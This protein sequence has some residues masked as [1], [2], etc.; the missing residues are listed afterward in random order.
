MMKRRFIIGLLAVYIITVFALFFTF[1]SRVKADLM[2]GYT[3]A[4]QNI[5]NGNYI[6]AVNTL[7]ILGSNYKDSKKLIV[8]SE[9]RIAYDQGK[10]SEAHE[11]FISL[12]NFKDS[13][14]WA[15]KSAEEES[16]TEQAQSYNK[17]CK[18]YVDG[19]Y[20]NALNI[21]KELEDYDKSQKLTE[22]CRS[23]WKMNCA[24]IVSAGIRYS[25][26]ITK[27]K[28]A[29]FSGQSFEDAADIESWHNIVSVSACGEF[30]LGLTDDGN[31]L[32]AKCKSHY[33]YSTDTS[34]WKNIIAVSA[35]EQL[36]AV[37]KDDGTVDTRG[38]DGYGERRDVGDW[39]D[40][41]AIDTGWQHIVGLDVNGDIHVAGCYKR[42][43]TDEIESK[44][45]DWTDI[46]SISTGG[47][48]G[49]DAEG[50]AYK[51]S[52]HIVAL[53]R[54]GTVVA[55]GDNE[56]GQCNVTGPEWKNIVAVSAGDYHTVGLT[57]DGRVVTTQSEERFPDSY[58]EIRK[59][60][61]IVSISAGYGFTLA[62]KSDG[63][64]LAAGLYQDGQ[65]NVELWDIISRGELVKSSRIV[66]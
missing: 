4:V 35:G 23:A 58:N 1:T 39:K 49:T 52:G 53:K 3:L 30:V 37:L 2:D 17:A 7:N 41:I 6:D 56:Y 22:L 20:L 19:D 5:D 42:K 24:E 66:N 50:N 54:D 59:W 32:V 11:K 51:G 26:G 60:E 64:V 15:E 48:T 43:L 13:Q 45:S 47:S 57:A 55:A 63:T 44:K 18:Y 29:A 46:V 16:I 9:G 36:I 38:V 40:I 27:D 62:V 33:N 8:Y 65:S 61:D 12:G 34:G 14:V 31:V 21:L 28:G 25:A 10:Y